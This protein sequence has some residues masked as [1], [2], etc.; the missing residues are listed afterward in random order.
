MSEWRKV[1]ISSI[2]T[3]SKIPDLSPSAESKIRVRLH[4][5]GVEKRPILAEKEGAT[6][7]YKRKVGQFI[8]GRQN[9]QK[10]AFGIIPTELDGFSSSADLPAF[11]IDESCLPEWLFYWFK[12]QNRYEHLIKVAKGIGSQRVS[13][14]DFYGVEILLPDL[15]TQKRIIDILKLLEIKITDLNVE[16]FNQKIYINKLRQSILQDAIEGKLTAEWRKQN[17]VIKGDPNTDAHALLNE[18]LIYW[19]SN[20][21]RNR[22]LKN[23]QSISSCDISS[24]VL[25]NIDSISTVRVGG[26]PSRS[27][28]NYWANDIQWVSSGEVANC[29]IF[30]TKESISV[31]G[32]NNSAAKTLPE[33]SVLVAM[34]GQ[35]KTRG[36]AAILRTQAATNQNVCG[37]L[38]DHGLIDSQF[39]FYYF[40]SKYEESRSFATG[41]NQPALSGEKIGNFTILL[42]PL[43]EQK[44]IANNVSSL[45]DKIYILEQQVI[46]RKIYTEQLMQAVLKEAFTP[47]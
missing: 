2:A 47:T 36:Q 10:G 44:L 23:G 40:L 6:K 37:L 17:S 18:I 33:G 25:T 20:N 42:P 22:A 45:L 1:K 7:Y 32:S 34:I 15:K 29:E 28:S 24:W 30:Q 19:K 26:T 11:D 3:E 13:T 9:F 35:G 21:T 38:V 41:G 12:T 8:Y 4:V 31:L 43:K 27:I 16:F 39:L 5:N 46:Q 14:A